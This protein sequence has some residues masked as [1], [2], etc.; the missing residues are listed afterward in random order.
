MEAEGEREKE[1]DRTIHCRHSSLYPFLLLFSHLKISTVFL[2]H[3]FLS[4]L[5]VLYERAGDQIAHVKF[6]VLL[7]SGGTTKIT[8][9]P[10]PSG[11]EVRGEEERLYGREGKR[12]DEMTREE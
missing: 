1:R 10:Q 4:V 2:S 11:F 6:T 12:R 5:A 9:L 7:Q 3:F 8:G